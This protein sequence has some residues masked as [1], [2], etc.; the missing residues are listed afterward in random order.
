MV[1]D[2]GKFIDPLADKIFV[3]A[4]FISFVDIQKKNVPAWMVIIIISREFIITGL[5][6]IA[7][8]KGTVLPATK[9]GKFKTTSQL[10]FIAVILIILFVNDLNVSLSY[11]NLYLLQNTIPYFLCLLVT[12]LTF[13]SGLSYLIKNRSLF[14][15]N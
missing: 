12:M 4:A 14:Y 11:E 3:C 10:V 6:T 15:N 9:S 2:F 7:M 5:R 13:F 1:T 8:S